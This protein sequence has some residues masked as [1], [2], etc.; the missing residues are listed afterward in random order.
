[1]RACMRL[2]LDAAKVHADF[3]AAHTNGDLEKEIKL[4]QLDNAIEAVKRTVR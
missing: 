1:M 3:M 4:D 2:V